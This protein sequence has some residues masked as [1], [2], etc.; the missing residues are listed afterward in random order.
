MEVLLRLTKPVLAK[1]VLAEK[2]ASQ[3]FK[4][5]GKLAVNARV[6]R[7]NLPIKRFNSA[8]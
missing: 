1:L 6:Y 5:S 7:C 8:F 4:Q 2:A 3:V